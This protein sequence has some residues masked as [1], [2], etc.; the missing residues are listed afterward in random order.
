METRDFIAHFNSTATKITPE[1]RARYLHLLDVILIEYRADLQFASLAQI[2]AEPD[3]FA[4]RMAA[5][6]ARVG[7]SKTTTATYVKKIW[8]IIRMHPQI[9]ANETLVQTWTHAIRHLEADRV[10]RENTHA[11]TERELERYLSYDQLMTIFRSI[12]PT[13]HQTRLL[14]ALYLLIPPVRNDYWNVGIINSA[15]DVNHCQINPQTG[16]I[17]LH[18]FHYKTSRTYGPIITKV[19]PDL[20]AVIRDSLARLP[21]EF[22]FVDGE[23]MPYKSSTDFT[24]WANIK[25]R[26]YTQVPTFSLPSFRHAY[27]MRPEVERMTPAERV[28]LSRQMGHDIGT[29]FKYI[30]SLDD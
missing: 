26:A 4:T 2:A 14:F 12:P 23:G 5:L 30:Y 20:A 15:D 25:L 21:R 16:E 18:L 6:G 24:R 27:V 22:L 11:A 10:V 19:P 1:N 13:Q 7:W 8:S 17:T 28:N 3:N 29:Q 9:A